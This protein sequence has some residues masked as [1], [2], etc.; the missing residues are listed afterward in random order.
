MNL[1]PRSLGAQLTVLMLGGF[2]VGTL[3][4]T[5]AMWSPNEALH[6]IAREHALSRTVT[7]YRLAQHQPVEDSRWLASFESPVARLWLDRS[8]SA[9]PMRAEELA[10][11]LE[12]NKRLPV[13][14]IAVHMPCRG[15]RPSA[16]LDGTRQPEIGAECVDIDLSLAD[17]RWLHTR[18][19]LPV[20]SL[21]SES[22][23]VVRLSLLIGIPPLLIIMYVFVNRI[24]RP[25]T[26]LTDAAERISQGER[27]DPLAMQGPDEIR[28]IAVA[29]NHM[30]ERITRFVDERTRMLAAIS[31][32]LRTPLTALE[33]QAV[34]LPPG[35]QRQ[36]MLRTLE[37]IRQMV[38]ETLRFASQGARSEASQR[39]DLVVLL[40]EVCGYHR[41]LGQQ[42]HLDAPAQLFYRCRPTALKRVFNNLVEN[43]CKHGTCVQVTLADRGRQGIAIEIA[44]DGPGIPEAMLER[45]F[46]P[47][48]QLDPSR[49]REAGGSVGLGLAIARD[50][51]QLHG[52]ILRLSNR[53]QGGLVAHLELPAIG[54]RGTA[55]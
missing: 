2:I 5:L 47:F 24:L 17:G 46:E 44:D 22:W 28:N 16:A 55:D 42:V 41:A 7:A 9:W 13:A 11:A 50:S 4:A 35:E 26:A 54:A 43:A 52:G 27:I 10:L 40:E 14:R 37:E 18:Q 48:F 30:Y 23:R 12:L 1:L 34:L 38:D 32:D 45:V 53:A 33:L 6:P 3:F 39:I 15:Q 25:T 51:I 36:E 21:W 20:Q 8:P 19:L 49:H 31:H 29:F